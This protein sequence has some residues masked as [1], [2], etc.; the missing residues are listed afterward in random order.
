M[1][2]IKTFEVGRYYKWVGPKVRQSGWNDAGG[3]DAVLDG[4][5]TLCTY[6]ARGC[7]AMFE[8]TPRS[9]EPYWDWA[10]GIEYW[11]KVQTIDD[12]IADEKAGPQR[13]N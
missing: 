4:K 13:E 6:A 2:Q 11:R 8:N 1:P 12:I 3:M 5:P 7:R 9:D 10:Y